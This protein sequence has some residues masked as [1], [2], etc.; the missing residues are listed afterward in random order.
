MHQIYHNPHQIYRALRARGGRT[1][2]GDPVLAALQRKIDELV[3]AE[4]YVHGP[5]AR[6]L[7]AVHE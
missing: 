2:M 3:R 1:S 7:P 6:V 4:A 5:A